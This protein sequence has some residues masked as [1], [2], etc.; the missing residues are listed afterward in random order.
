MPYCPQ[1]RKER[2][3][4]AFQSPVRTCLYCYAARPWNQDLEA[5]LYGDDPYMKQQAAKQLHVRA[6]QSRFSKRL[7]RRRIANSVQP[8]IT[9]KGEWLGAS[10]FKGSERALEDKALTPCDG[11]SKLFENLT[12][13]SEAPGP[14]DG[15]KPLVCPTCAL[16]PSGIER[17]CA[18]CQ[19]AFPLTALTSDGSPK[20]RCVDCAEK[21]SKGPAKAIR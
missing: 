20:L 4:G 1:C 10:P 2:E 14:D 16:N 21:L 12:E 5:A 3:D 11:C 17:N 13:V 6:F 9:P 15:P 8:Q 19:K 18:L 7:Q